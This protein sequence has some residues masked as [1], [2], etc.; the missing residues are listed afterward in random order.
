MQ[1]KILIWSHLYINN[2]TFNK[3]YVLSGYIY[4]FI[5]LL[6]N[7]SKAYTITQTIVLGIKP[8]HYTWYSNPHFSF[9]LC[10]PE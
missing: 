4:C 1:E 5:S 10:T 6:R 9:V 7:I 2:M 3:K 8:L